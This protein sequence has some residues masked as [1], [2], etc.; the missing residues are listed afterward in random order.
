[1]WLKNGYMREH[2]Y[3]PIIFVEAGQSE[4]TPSAGLDLL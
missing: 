4:A 2:A 3:I 1:M